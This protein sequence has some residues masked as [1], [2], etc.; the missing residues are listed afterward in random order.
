MGKHSDFQ[1]YVFVGVYL[2]EKNECASFVRR[3]VLVYWFSNANWEY[4]TI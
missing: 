3:A 1:Y 2:N 4:H